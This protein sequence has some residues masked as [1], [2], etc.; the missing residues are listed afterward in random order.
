MD[1]IHNYCFEDLVQ[2]CRDHYHE[3]EERKELSY[4]LQNK[5]VR[6]ID[7][8]GHFGYTTFGNFYFTTRDAMMLVTKEY[9]MTFYHQ[10][11]SMRESLWSTVPVLFAG[12]ETGMK[13]CKGREIYSCDVL[14]VTEPTQCEGVVTWFHRDTIPC[15]RLDNHCFYLNEVRKCE[16]MG[17]VFFDIEEIDYEYYHFDKFNGNNPF[18]QGPVESKYWDERIENIK[19]APSFIGVKPQPVERYPM[20]YMNS[21][22]EVGLRKGDVLVAFS[23]ESIIDPNDESTF[24]TLYIDRGVIPDDA[25]YYCE[26]IPV[27]MYNPDWRKVE[28]MV[29]DLLLKVHCHPDIRYFLCDMKETFTD[30]KERKE[31]GRIFKKA[32]DFEIRNFIMPFEIAMYE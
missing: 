21:V 30:K 9:P 12:I 3:I 5:K 4:L 8:E 16:I 13:D 17:N 29:D 11:D 15:V 22:T 14:S 20:M 32:S 24:P 26:N 1:A 28:K 27:D 19:N 2:L 7:Q 10:P 31:I 25:K 23:D 6:Y 18:F